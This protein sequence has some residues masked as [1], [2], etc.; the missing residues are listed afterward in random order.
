M[1]PTRIRCRAC[2]GRGSERGCR[3]DVCEGSGWI[4]LLVDDEVIDVDQ[5]FVEMLDEDSDP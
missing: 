4:L 5:E 1:T 2:G 3:C